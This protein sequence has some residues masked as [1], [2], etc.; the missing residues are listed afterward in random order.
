M[1]SFTIN[2]LGKNVSELDA[3][4]LTDEFKKVVFYDLE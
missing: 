4:V 2:I 1:V 3:L